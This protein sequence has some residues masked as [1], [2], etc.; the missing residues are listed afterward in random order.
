MENRKLNENTHNIKKGVIIVI[1]GDGKGKTTSAI[2][3]IIRAVGHKQKVCFIQFIKGNWK[4]GEMIF[5]SENNYVDYHISGEGFTWDSKDINKDIMAA[6]KGWEIA[7][8]AILSDNYEL[9]VLDEFNLVLDYNFIDTNEV[10]EVIKKK[11]NDTSII[12]TGRN[13]NKD[14]IEIADTVSNIQPIKHA[15]EANILAKKGVEY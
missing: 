15:Y 1:T 5:F 12:L 3:T 9:I 10:I 13:A 11:N 4:T 7:K 14:I 8:K 2:G 6:K